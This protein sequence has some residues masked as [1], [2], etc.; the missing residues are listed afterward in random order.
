MRRIESL[1]PRLMARARIVAVWTIAS[2]SLAVVPSAEMLGESRVAES[3]SE[4]P[5]WLRGV[6]PNDGHTLVKALAGPAQAQPP[7]QQEMPAWMRRGLPEDGHAALK[8]LVGTWRARL[9]IYGTLGRRGD[10]PPIVSEDVTTRRQWVGD[11]RVLE[12]TTEGTVMG[13][14]I[15]R[16][17]WLAYSNMERR[18]EWVTID[19]INTTMMSYK[20]APGSGPRLPISLVGAFIDQGVAGEETVGKRVQMR[21][22]L[23]IDNNDRHVFELFFTRP[24]AKETLATRYTYS[25]VS[26]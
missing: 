17:G 8:P 19:N 25:R 3:T 6:Q 12:D 5:A 16:A 22:V 9:E 21:T 10:E 18:Y 13:M 4:R 15:W 26:E 2:L 23:R 11:G 24:G 1:F 7:N 14:P 20:S